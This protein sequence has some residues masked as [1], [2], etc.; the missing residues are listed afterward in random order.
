M[1][2]PVRYKSIQSI[3]EEATAKIWIDNCRKQLYVRK[4]KTQYYI[5]TWHGSVNLKK[6]E[7]DAEKQL[8]AYY[9]KQA[10]NDSKLINLLLSDS[11][12]ASQIYRS[13]FWYDGAIFECGCPR[14]DILIHPVQAAK[15]KARKY[16][17]IADNAKIILYAPTFRDT[18]DINIYSLN[19][20]PILRVLREK[21]GD[22]WIF[23][24]RLHPNISE[25]SEAFAYN[26][27]TI[28][29]ATNYDDMQ[30]LMLV[31]DI[32]ITDYSDCMYEFALMRKPVFL[33]ITDYE[34]YKKER[35]LYFD[36]F[37]LPFPCA[38]NFQ[39]LLEKMIQFNNEDY[40]SSL[41]VFFET[42]GIVNDGKASE[43]VVNKIAAETKGV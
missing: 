28:F 21:T 10:I 31:S 16:F 27:K 33:Y 1:V 23:L 12:F 34:E 25:K 41:A 2:K 30:E 32:L 8:S 35:G 24:V 7:K 19:H 5:Q 37:S 42:V 15:D 17:N 11:K 36:L 13:A 18:F 29:N 20:T 6:V 14:D 4:R 39:E 40:V 38:V 22:D 26:N 9:I 43:L 3:F